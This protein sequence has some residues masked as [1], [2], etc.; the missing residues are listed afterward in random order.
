[1]QI[2]IIGTT[3]SG[4]SDLALNIA[5]QTNSIILSLDSL[6]VYKEIDIASAKP[7]HAQM[8]SIKHFG[9]DVIRPDESFNVTIFFD[10]YKMAKKEAQLK[11]VP[12]IIV[13][14]TSFYLKA[15]L[16]GL[17]DKPLV[18]KENQKKTTRTLR[19]IKNAYEYLTQTDPIMGRKI[20]ANDRYRIEKWYEIYF[21]TGKIPSD[22]L[23]RTKK[24]PLIKHLPIF[25]IDTDKDILQQRI[26]VRTKK[27]ISNGLVDEIARL[28]KKYTR[29]PNCMKAI[30]IKEVIDYFDGLYSLKQMEEKIIINTSKLAKR[31]RTFNKTQ[32]IQ[33]IIK[34]PLDK[35]EK[36]IMSEL[37]SKSHMKQV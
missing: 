17:S 12:L 30:G 18:S 1:M 6:C 5:K 15:M 28:E 36:A 16:S 7:T 13:G 8:S 26:A 23:Q 34:K 22:F 19:D 10:L 32:F 25:E 4:K 20:E 37:T 21:E 2:A 29:E 24:E 35:M 33:P 31:Q 11:S 3:A 9:I 14:G 27:M